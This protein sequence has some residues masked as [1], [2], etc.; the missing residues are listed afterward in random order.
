MSVGVLP[1]DPDTGASTSEAVRSGTV[2]LRGAVA[3]LTLRAN[4][5][6]TFLSNVIYAACQWGIVVCLVWLTDAATVG[7]FALGLA[8][9]APVFMFANLNLRSLQATDAN[10]TWAF[11]EYLRL[12]LLTTT[13]AIMVISG[14]CLAAGYPLHTALVV[15]AVGLA[16]ALESISEVYYG[17]LQQHERMDRIAISTIVRGVLS[18]A[19]MTAIVY[20]TGD[21]LWGALGL[22]ASWGVV[23]LVYD[24]R[25]VS[26][27]G[28]RQ[29]DWPACGS[30][31]RLPGRL[32]R[33]AWRAAPLGLV[34]F[35]ISLTANLPRYFFD[36]GA[37][38]LRELGIFAALS[39]LVVAG[40]LVIAA[41]GQSATP[42]LARLFAAGDRPAFIALLF[43]IIAVSAS[44]GAA[45]V[46]VALAAGKP[47]LT[48]L[49]GAE[50]G[51]FAE[52]FVWLM[53]AGGLGYVA[54]SL[55]YAITAT[56]SFAIQVPLF[57]VVGIATLVSCAILIPQN[58]LLGA[59]F[60]L[61]ISAGVQ[62]AA[63]AWV[64][65]RIA[66]NRG[67]EVA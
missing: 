28:E 10:G 33:L 21:I 23:L 29:A 25:S 57:L 54:S 39:Y 61:V 58:G 59:A 38:G 12:R 49:Y 14:I 43:R 52:V 16:K 13:A 53:L 67:K 31:R 22:A 8:I 4:C 51:A 18:L 30:A 44:C 19:V 65:Y 63:S 5:A 64:L 2:P 40:G 32:V 26:R 56:Q 9:T 34:M 1:C 66:A 62:L 3:T 46:L 27:F 7:V 6:W 60:A 11:G 47:L 24:L 37:P 36:P 55:G 45:G 35:L 20:V 42:R 41:V 50:Y 15:L 48:L 17:F